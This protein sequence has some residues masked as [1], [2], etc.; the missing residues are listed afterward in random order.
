MPAQSLRFL[1]VCVLM[2]CVASVRRKGLLRLPS[3]FSV[4][5]GCRGAE[6]RLPQPGEREKKKSRVR[7][8]DQ[9]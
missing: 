4:H 5:S 8:F 3:A 7:E 1:V 2:E 6:S 9:V